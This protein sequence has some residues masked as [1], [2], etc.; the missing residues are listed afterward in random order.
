MMPADPGDTDTRSQHDHAMGSRAVEDSE[1]LPGI[2]NMK[3]VFGAFCKGPHCSGLTCPSKRLRR[4]TGSASHP[5]SKSSLH[6]RMPSYYRTRRTARKQI[7]EQTE[8]ESKKVQAQARFAKPP[9]FCATFGP[10][11][12]ELEVK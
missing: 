11:E 8:N 1:L 12:S 2:R 6:D 5:R 9:E 10:G 4:S 3:P 7:T